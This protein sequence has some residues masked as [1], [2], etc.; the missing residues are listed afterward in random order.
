MKPVRIVCGTRS[1][2]SEFL[3]KSALGR[4]LVTH[5]DANPVD[6][7]LFP[8]NSQGL[9]ALYNYAI[10]QARDKPAILVF[11]HDDVHFCDFHWSESIARGTEQFDVVGVAGNTRRVPMQPS[12]VFVD[13]R[14]TWDEKRYL[15]G[16][17]AH[18]H[19][20]PS[21][22][23]YFGP[24]AQ[25][26]KLL[27]GLLL[28]ADS[29]RLIASGVRFDEQFKFHF[30]DMDFCRQVELAGLSMGTWPLSVVHESGGAFGSP[31]WREA[32]SRYRSKYPDQM[33]FRDCHA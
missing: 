1:T 24:S 6:V 10:E 29:E 14:F 31:S 17:V 30:Y 26:C 7:L 20:F 27:D 13:D 33:Q 15:S 4:S 8:E 25:A 18:G 9:S 2:Q 21:P 32:L 16:L 12:W 19:G 22:I 28:A 11:V 23:S 5:R 3:E